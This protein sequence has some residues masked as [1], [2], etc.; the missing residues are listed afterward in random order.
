MASRRDICD[1]VSAG[2]LI[3]AGSTV[4]VLLSGGGDSVCLLAVLHELIGP[5][6]LAALHVNHGLRERADADQAFCEQLCERLSTPLHV[7]RLEIASGSGNVEAEA[8]AARYRAAEAIRADRALDLIATGHTAGDQ[9]ETVLYRLVASPG[10][11]SLLGIA[12]RNGRIVRP[13]LGVTREQTHQY[14]RDVGLEW[15]DDETNL[16]TSL[17]R[18]RIRH[19]IM[20]ALREIHPAAEQNIIATAQELREESALLDSALQEA[21]ERSAAGGDPPAVES[22][23]LAGLPTPLRRLVLRHLAERAAGAHVPLGPAR[24]AELERL[25]LAPGSSYIDLPGG[26]RA[27]CEYGVIRFRKVA[28]ESDPAPVELAVPGSCRFGSWLVL[29]EP[30]EAGGARPHSPDEALLDR[31]RLA[32]RLEV[33]AWRPG[34]RMRPLGLDGTKSLQDLF[35]DLKI[36]RSLRSTLPVVLSAGEVAWVGGVAV[37]ENFKAPPQGGDVVRLA[38]RASTQSVTPREP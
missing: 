27:A 38:A 32:D 1:V 12:E 35:T 11:R 24:V 15:C 22:S 3:P 17:A 7:Q 25:A 31:S 9:A 20:P 37:S 33:R 30:S 13:L 8:R 34:D 16:D 26:V 14:C 21:L 5:G 4:L 10:R 36:P 2:D 23:A 18:N 19:E 6:R 29:C 28:G